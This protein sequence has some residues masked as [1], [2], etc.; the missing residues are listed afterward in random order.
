[1]VERIVGGLPLDIANR[2]EEAGKWSITEVLQHLADSELVFGYRLR[3]VIAHDRPTL[4]GYDQDL[5]ANRLRY[6]G[7]DAGQSLQ[8]FGQLRDINLRMLDRVGTDAFHRV[9]MHTE[10]GEETV[11]HML[12]LY[13]GHDLLHIRQLEPGAAGRGVM[14][15]GRDRIR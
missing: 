14:V 1:V 5:W 13:A 11:A 6:Q 7:A 3:M 8:D 10:R 15:R 9:G 2:S 4:T 12:R